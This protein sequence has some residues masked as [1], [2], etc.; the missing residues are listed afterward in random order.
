LEEE[1]GRRNPK[2]KCLGIIEYQTK[3][4]PDFEG[5][6]FQTRFHFFMGT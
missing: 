4:R 2:H 3:L 5:T 1:A 6:P